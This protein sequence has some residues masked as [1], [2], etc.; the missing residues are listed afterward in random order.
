MPKQ[1]FFP[2]DG[3]KPGGAYSPAIR[4]GDMIFIAG[5]VPADPET[6]EILQAPIAQ[7][8]KLVFENVER[9][10]KAAGASLDDCC[11][12]RVYLADLKDFAAMN[13][14]YKTF[15]KEPYPARTTC[16]VGLGKFNIEVDAI[17]YKPQ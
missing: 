5:Q 15:F 7:T 3:P 9:A 17:A 12:V 2:S 16:Q 14:V 1:A 4:A 10:L 11:H 13:E 8:T 6:N